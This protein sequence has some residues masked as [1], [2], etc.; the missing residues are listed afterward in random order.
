MQKV[1]VVAGLALVVTAIIWVAASGP[2]DKKKKGGDSDDGDFVTTPSGLK[3]R[4]DKVGKGKEAKTGDAVAVHYTGTFPDGKKFDSSVDRGQPFTFTLGQGGVIKGWDEGV[5]GMKE[6]GKRT[7][8]IP[9]DLAY[10]P[11]GRGSIPPNAELHFVID[12]LK[13]TN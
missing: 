13:V 12:L 8:I 2:A 3:Y 1:L 10:G 5:V 6:G 11:Q 7:L 4:D 9:S